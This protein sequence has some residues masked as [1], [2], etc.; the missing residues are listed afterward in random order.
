M[1]RLVSRFAP[2]SLKW[3][4]MKKRYR[5]MIGICEKVAQFNGIALEEEKLY[6]MN[7]PK[8]PRTKKEEGVA[9]TY[10][11]KDILKSKYLRL[12]MLLC[13]YIWWV[14]VHS[15]SFLPEIQPS[16]PEC[17]SN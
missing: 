3:L 14:T 15:I 11:T 6:E 4:S 7:D 10:S 17:T 16:L 8:H 1:F 9:Q 2:E 13:C 12:F 5:E